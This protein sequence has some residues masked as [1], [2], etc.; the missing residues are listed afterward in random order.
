LHQNKSL[1]AENRE[2]RKEIA[3]FR[4]GREDRRI[5]KLREQN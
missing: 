3:V 1:E 5:M 2:L 4:T